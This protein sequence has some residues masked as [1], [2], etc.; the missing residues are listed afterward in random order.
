MVD[1]DD[2]GEDVFHVWRRRERSETAARDPVSWVC[3]RCHPDL[4]FPGPD[5][6]G[7]RAV[8]DG[9]TRPSR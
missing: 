3:E 9:G 2:C 7:G 1:C 8:T 6:S 5:G 4:G